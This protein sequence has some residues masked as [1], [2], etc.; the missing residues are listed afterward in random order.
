MNTH[1]RSKVADLARRFNTDSE[2]DR[3]TQ[4]VIDAAELEA[5]VASLGDC[6]DDQLGSHIRMAARLIIRVT[7]HA[8]DEAGM[9]TAD[10]GLAVSALYRTA[11]ISLTTAREGTPVAETLP[12]L[13]EAMLSAVVAFGYVPATTRAEAEAVV[14]EWLDGIDPSRSA[15]PTRTLAIGAAR[16]LQAVLV[17]L[18]G[19][20]D[21]R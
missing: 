2:D 19:G 8:L 9:L 14:Y 16:A 3:L 6:R 17:I 1:T 13:N 10:I 4:G 15:S 12:D 20:V 18:D 11:Q 21:E 5:I 7:R